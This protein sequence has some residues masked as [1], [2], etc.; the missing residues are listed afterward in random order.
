MDQIT[1]DPP[2][3]I[4]RLTAAERKRFFK[5]V[6]DF[7]TPCTD[8]AAAQYKAQAPK[9]AITAQDVEWMSPAQ[10][11]ELL[12]QVQAGEAHLDPN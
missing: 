4:G 8:A 11:R 1:S 2:F 10:R 12:D 9:K 6:Y 5:D 3:D 7:R